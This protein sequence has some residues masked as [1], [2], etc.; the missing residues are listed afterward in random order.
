MEMLQLLE[1]LHTEYHIDFRA[2]GFDTLL[3]ALISRNELI[4]IYII[5]KSETARAFSECI[6]MNSKEVRL[7]H[8]LIFTEKNEAA[9]ELLMAV[10]ED[11]CDG[12]KPT[13]S[14]I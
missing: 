9:Y 6:Q 5:Q 14:L 2:D 1:I 13:D 3:S 12:D 4:A 7:I 10:A 8:H 11:L